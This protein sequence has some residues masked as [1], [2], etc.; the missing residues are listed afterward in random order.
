MLSRSYR[1][2]RKKQP[3]TKASVPSLEAKPFQSQPFQSQQK[4]HQ[5]LQ[6]KLKVGAPDSQFEK[7]ADATADKVMAN[8]SLQRR[9]DHCQEEEKGVE[10]R[11]QLQ[12]QGQEEEEESIQ[13]KALN[14]LQR[15]EQQEE[16]EQL[17]T[18]SLDQIDRQEQ[19][20]EEEEL[21]TKPY[22]QL[23]RQEQ[24]PEEEE[25]LAKSNGQSGFETSNNISNRIRQNMS[26]GS[27]IP[28]SD[29]NFFESRFNRDFSK[30]KVHTDKEAN[31]LSQAVGAKAFTLGNH[32]FFNDGQ[33]QPGSSS[34][35]HLMAHELTH[36]LQQKGVTSKEIHRKIGS[37]SVATGKVT[38]K[39]SIALVGPKATSALATKWKNAIE[40]NW[41]VNTTI[42]GTPY[43]LEVEAN[44]VAKPA[45][46]KVQGLYGL[47]EYNNIIE[48]VK[49]GSRSFVSGSCG[50]LRPSRA[51]GEWQEDSADLVIA[52]ETGHLMGLGDKYVDIFGQSYDL[53]GYDKDIM[54]NF[55]NDGGN[56]DFTHAWLRILV[57]H[58]TSIV[59]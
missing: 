11:D 9:C 8:Q 29:K 48:V 50:L 31:Q 53:P 43:L 30:V 4:V 10:A 38:V 28:Q 34:S 5:I 12:R 58:F 15:Q 24:K 45:I 55:W 25:V 26:K 54:A 56:T 51:C 41:R 40:N 36:T 32:V 57:H 49:N 1:L 37:V 17:Q 2:R 22:G 3:V 59:N 16:E 19:Q 27:A 46:S 35:R 21:Q 18:K 23:N 39:L 44:V 14:Q 42:G 7:D 20:E 47:L 52:H 6:P 33:Y 13:T